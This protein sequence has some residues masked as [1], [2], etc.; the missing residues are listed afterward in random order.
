[1]EHFRFLFEAAKHR[2]VAS[3]APTSGPS[4]RQICKPIPTD[5]PCVIVELGPGTGAFTRWL[6]KILHPDS[7]LIAIELNEQF[8]KQLRTT[9]SETEHRGCRFDV[10]HGDANDL[11]QWLAH[12]GYEHADYVLSGIPF[13]LLPPA[14]RHSIVL[15]AYQSLRTGGDLIVYQCS[16]LMKELL[17]EFFDEVRM[18]RCLLNLPP[19]CVMHCV[20]EKEKPAFTGD[21]NPQLLEERFSRRKHKTPKQ[22]RRWMGRK[23]SFNSEI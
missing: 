14:L 13:S 9:S 19:L 16:F 17:C 1:M 6:L 20:K 12:Y 15:R 18:G 11:R 23:P 2:E 8:V 7:H 21:V 5:R 3:V 22:R 4:V 10:V